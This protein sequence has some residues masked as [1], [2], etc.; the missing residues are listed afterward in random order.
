VPGE[1]PAL[2]VIIEA[3]AREWPGVLRR[4]RRS[5]AHGEQ[6]PGGRQPDYSPEHPATIS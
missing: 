3:Y 1:L 2:A 4:R 5:E 6:E